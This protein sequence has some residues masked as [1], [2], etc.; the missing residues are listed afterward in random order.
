MA[1]V[2]EPPD[3]TLGLGFTQRYCSC[4]YRIFERNCSSFGLGWLSDG[5]IATH[6]TVIIEHYTIYANITGKTVEI[7][8]KVIP[9]LSGP[10]GQ[11]RGRFLKVGVQQRWRDLLYHAGSSK[12]FVLVVNLLSVCKI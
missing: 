11:R 9:A 6:Y 10:R 3:V 12:K 1:Q 5:H 7:T 8:V 2:C 4:P